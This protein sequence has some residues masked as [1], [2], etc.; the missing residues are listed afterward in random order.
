MVE[1]MEAMGDGGEEETAG[2]GSGA[3]RFSG[4]AD[5]EEHLEADTRLSRTPASKVAGPRLRSS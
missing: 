4:W 5:E 3:M 1:V 2:D